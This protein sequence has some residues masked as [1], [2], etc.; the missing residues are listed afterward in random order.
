MLQEP[1]PLVIGYAR[2]SVTLRRGERIEYGEQAIGHFEAGSL[3]G[4]IA[5][6]LMGTD[7]FCGELEHLYETLEGDTELASLDGDLTIR[8]RAGTLG[9]V[10]VEVRI[11]EEGTPEID[12]AYRF[13]MD[14]SFLP[15]I[16]HGLK[17][18]FPGRR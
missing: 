7:E 6:I 1:E 10:A 2:A 8:F 5:P 13:G 12:L 14:Q 18:N 16:I 4:D 17:A 3:R 9:S 11:R 15:A